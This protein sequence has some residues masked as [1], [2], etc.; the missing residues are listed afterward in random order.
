M[1]GKRLFF[2]IYIFNFFLIQC[3]ADM[4]PIGPNRRT[5]LPDLEASV[6]MSKKVSLYTTL[7]SSH[8]Q[9][10][11]IFRLLQPDLQGCKIFNPPHPYNT[12]C[13]RTILIVLWN[14]GIC[15]CLYWWI[16]SPVICFNSDPILILQVLIG[17]E[18]QQAFCGRHSFGSSGFPKE[19]LYATTQMKL[20][21][22]SDFSNQERHTGFAAYYVAAGV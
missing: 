8:Y 12:M 10:G 14:L 17:N 4:H 20:L 6:F 19:K 16:C 18:V 5:K 22:K 3:N 11:W 21:F 7:L 15:F 13:M 9:A 1:R 2:Y